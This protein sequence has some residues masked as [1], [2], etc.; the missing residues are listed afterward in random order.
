MKNGIINKGLYLL[1]AL[2]CTIIGLYPILYLLGD[3]PFGILNS[4]SEQLLASMFWTISFY[5]HILLGGVALLIGWIQFSKKLRNWNIQLHKI[6]GKIYVIAVLLSA[7][8]GIY[9]GFFANGGLI[10][11]AGFISL[12]IIWFYTTF[13]GYTYAKAKKIED[14]KNM[15][16]YSYAACFAAVSLRLWM[17]LLIIIFEDA[18][19]AYKFV[20]WWCWIPNLLVAY[21]I[22]RRQKSNGLI[23]TI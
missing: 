3:S 10:P 15:M 1:L 23:K 11:S 16:I 6:I 21:L 4:K 18:G 14:H 17:P 22:I 19:L 9:I 8:G 2:L 13:K 7:L 20:S 12:G 5:T